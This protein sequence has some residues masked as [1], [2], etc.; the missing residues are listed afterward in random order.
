LNLPAGDLR[1]YNPDL[2]SQ[3][4]TPSVPLVA[5]QDWLAGRG[6]PRDEVAER[7]LVHLPL[8]SFKYTYKNNPYTAVVEGATGKVLAN[9]FP[10]KA[11]TPYRTVGC[12][13]AGVFLLLASFPIIGALID[14]AAGFGVGMLVC[15]GTGL[16]AVPLLFAAAAWV[17]QKV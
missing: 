5:A 16:V 11:E 13:T 8:Y 12:L 7:A 4:V 2:D 10:A 17:A 9:I 3:A 15:S 14:G 6:V 1:K